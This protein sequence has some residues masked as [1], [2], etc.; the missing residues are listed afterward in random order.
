MFNLSAVCEIVTETRLN[1]NAECGVVESILGPAPVEHPQ[2][3]LCGGDTMAS[4]TT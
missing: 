1:G 4:L 3:H 2:K